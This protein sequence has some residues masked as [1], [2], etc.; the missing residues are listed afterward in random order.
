MFLGEVGIVTLYVSGGFA[1]NF[2]VADDGILHH[3]VLQKADFVNIFGIA[4]DTF[5][6][7][8][9]MGD[10]VIEP[11][12]VTAHTATASD[13]TLWRNEFGSALG[14][15]TSTGTPSIFCRRF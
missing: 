11:L 13:N 7:L 8:Q 10:V 15:S 2:N 9:D 12:L 14:V 6:R 5:Y 3:V 4:I 1:D